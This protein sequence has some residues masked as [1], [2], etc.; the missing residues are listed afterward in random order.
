M[1]RDAGWD[2]MYVNHSW[3]RQRPPGEM[4]RR[5][6]PGAI[7]WWAELPCMAALGA[8]VLIEIVRVVRTPVGGQEI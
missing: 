8:M 3:L 5:S 4:F 7:T 2:E 1:N 6:M